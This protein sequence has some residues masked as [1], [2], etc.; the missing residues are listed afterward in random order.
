MSDS[1]KAMLDAKAGQAA[2]QKLSDP[3]AP[4]AEVRLDEVS[5]TPDLPAGTYYV[6]GHPYIFRTGDYVLAPVDGVYTPVTERQKADLA[7]HTQRGYIGRV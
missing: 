1:L 4:P 2:D 5:S 7:F 6:T 3:K